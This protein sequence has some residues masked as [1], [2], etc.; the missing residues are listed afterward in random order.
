MRNHPF[1]DGNKRTGFLAA[2]TFLRINGL[3]FEA[4]QAEVVAFVLAVA[5]GAIDEDGIAAFLR[6]HCDSHPSLTRPNPEQFPLARRVL[7]MGA[8]E[9]LAA[10]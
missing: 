8:R 3:E 6:D 5:A 1:S 9:M 7:A 4:T 2:Y 10:W